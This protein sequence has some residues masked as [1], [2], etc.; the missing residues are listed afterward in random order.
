MYRTGSTCISELLPILRVDVNP[1]EIP[2]GISK[3]SLSLHSH[4]DEVACSMK[5]KVEGKVR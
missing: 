1:T 2:T 5:K 4:V 3:R